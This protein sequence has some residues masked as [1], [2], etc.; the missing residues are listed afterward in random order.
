MRICRA[1]GRRRLAAAL[2]RRDGRQ[3]R[4]HRHRARA[5]WTRA[6]TGIVRS[7][8]GLGGQKCSALSRVYVEDARG[9]RAARAPASTKMAAHRAS[10]IRRGARTGWGRSSRRGAARTSTRY[11]RRSCAAAA[12]RILAGGARLRDGELAARPLRRAD[13]RRGA[14]RPS[15]VRG[16]DVPADPDGARGCRTCDEALRRANDSPLGPHRRLLR[17]RRRGAAA[18]STTSRPASPT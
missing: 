10:A 15:A 1:D 14:G 6:A 12:A 5:I 4:L 2:H 13:A 11:C 7:A 3:E 18:S 17:Q 8:F 9:R 16:G